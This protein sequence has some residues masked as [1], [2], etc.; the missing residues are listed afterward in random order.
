MHGWRVNL[1]ELRGNSTAQK[2]K[3]THKQRMQALWNYQKPDRVPISGFVGGFPNT[4]AG[5]RVR[6][7]YDDPHTTFKAQ[8]K[9]AEQYCWELQP[10][11]FR[12]TILAGWD[13][14]GEIKMPDRDCEVAYSVRS[15]PVQTEEDVWKL[16]MPD[17]KTAG[18]L[19][20]S[21]IFAKLQ[22]EN[23]LQI[24]FY[25]RSPF[26]LAANICGLELFCRWLIEKPELCHKLIRM[27]KDHILNVWRVWTDTFGADKILFIMSS[28]NE[29]NHI[30]SPKH[31]EKFA[32]PY[33]IELHKRL[34]TIGI[35]RFFFHICGKQK[36]NLPYLAEISYLWPHPSILSF[37]QEVDLE[38]AANYFPNDIIY[39]NIDPLV[40]DKGTPQQVY[41]L[42]KIAIEKGK[43]ISGGFILAPGCE[44][45]IWSP[46]DN[47]FAMTKAVYDCG[48][49]K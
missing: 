2:D 36:L 38:I 28:P 7:A 8:L 33:H 21:M 19:V 1:V 12:H 25:T 14:G 44:I 45:G 49:Y 22:E 26:S 34:Q 20:N 41:E 18:G 6:T 35:R 47:V 3:M 37:G 9:T 15:L 30:I 16:K 31:L 27:A 40:I 39:G 46:H 24:T 48:W 4:N 17:P 42:S 23:N 11:A 10:Q 43:R 29:S 5:Y 13:F 32:V